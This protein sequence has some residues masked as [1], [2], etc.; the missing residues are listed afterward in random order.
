MHNSII[1]IPPFLY[2]VEGVFDINWA[3]VTCYM[4]KSLTKLGQ[5][6][7]NLYKFYFRSNKTL[8]KLLSKEN[9]Y[10]IMYMIWFNCCLGISFQ[11]RHF[12][13]NN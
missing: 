7:I 10:S 12:I 8:N 4:A 3:T 2:H 11:L 5:C 13:K 9:F 6:N 1:E